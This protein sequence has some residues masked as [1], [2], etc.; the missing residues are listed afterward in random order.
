MLRAIW[1][2]QPLLP[3]PSPFYL[4]KLAYNFLIFTL[5]L[6]TIPPL[7]SLCVT[8]PCL[9]LNACP[10]CNVGMLSC[11]HPHY[12]PPPIAVKTR[13]QL[14]HLYSDPTT[15]CTVGL[16]ICNYSL[17][18]LKRTRYIQPGN[19][20]TILTLSAMPLQSATTSPSL[21]QFCIRLHRWNPRTKLPYICPRTGVLLVSWECCPLLTYPLC[22]GKPATT[23][24]FLLRS[25]ARLH[26]WNCRT[27]LPPICYLMHALYV[28][29]ACSPLLYP[30][31]YHPLLLLQLAYNFP[32]SAPILASII[33]FESSYNTPPHLSLNVRATCNLGMLSP[34]Y[35]TLIASPLRLANRLQLYH[36][37]SNPVNDCT[38]GIPI[39]TYPIPAYDRACCIDLGNHITFLIL[40][41]SSS[42]PPS[43]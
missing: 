19:A 23:L 27:N 38:V 22:F 30:I 5:I 40:S 37:Y 12:L 2:C 16:V 29:W 7:E 15:N 34:S 4:L 41:P 36:S 32:I 20:I 9:L 13:L 35:F 18:T 1:E 24:P 3:V 28:T 43:P 8:T 42:P 6:Q 39:W 17:C 31:T 14:S 10:M 33:P 25:C 26:R 21:L 11:S